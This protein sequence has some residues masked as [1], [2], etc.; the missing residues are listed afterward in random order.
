MQRNVHF[1]LFK[2]VNKCFCLNNIQRRDNAERKTGN[3]RG[4]KSEIPS[5]S[6]TL[7]GLFSILYCPDRG[8]VSQHTS[9]FYIKRGTSIFSES[10]M[11]TL[12]FCLHRR[13]RT[14]SLDS[15][16]PLEP[17]HVQK[18]IFSEV[19]IFFQPSWLLFMSQAKYAFL[20][21]SCKLT[22]GH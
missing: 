6:V 20:V 8:S 7:Q 5:F 1:W 18:K 11:T 19:L 16:A 21:I 17:I 4:K 22:H 13:P 14:T 15:T 9:G 3:A 2:S 10:H 12:R